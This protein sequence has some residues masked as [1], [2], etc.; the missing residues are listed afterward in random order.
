M[1]PPPKKKECARQ[2]H[3]RLR[4]VAPLDPRFPL[5]LPGDFQRG[6]AAVA[7]A[8]ANQ[9][10]L[11]L[12]SR[13]PKQQPPQPPQQPQEEE[14]EGEG[15][16]SVMVVDGIVAG[17]PVMAAALRD[18]SW[19][20]RC[21]RVDW[22]PHARLFIDG[23]HTE[24]SMGV[25][26]E[27]YDGQVAALT[28]SVSSSPPVQGRRVLLFHCGEEKAVGE[29]LRHLIFAGREPRFGLVFFTPVASARP[30]L[31]AVRPARDLVL[32]GVAGQGGGD[33]GDDS[34]A[35]RRRLEALCDA[36]EAE[37]E[38]EGMPGTPWQWALRGAWRVLQAAALDGPVDTPE[39]ARALLA[40]AD[41][42][43]ETRTCGGVGGA[44]GELRA[45]GSGDGGG[46]GPLP[47]V[48]V[49]GSLYLVGNV[50]E[51]VVPEYQ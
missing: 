48:L 49:T 44:L 26:V 46:E 39:G 34:E 43:T 51:R 32:A 2:A 27:W 40:R 41:A 8:L 38:E 36:L 16:E 50:L 45:M 42:A 5:G 47:E 19:P 30:T 33:G 28:S 6:N 11:L 25:A 31:A 29:L 1:L 9:L 18:C 3:V 35:A 22:P 14:Q 20:G 13:A 15:A 17:D 37:E 10:L 23:A 4:R 24:Q 7:V 21:Q 12:A